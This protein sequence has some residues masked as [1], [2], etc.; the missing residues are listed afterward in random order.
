METF[1]CERQALVLTKPGCARLWLSAQENE[2]KPWEGRAKCL[3][4]PIGAAHA[5]RTIAPMAEITAELK[6]ICPRC[7][8]FA[9]RLIGKR[10]CVSCYN[11]Q[12]EVIVG[13]NAKGN[14]PLLASVLH[15]E[16]V[17]AVGPSGAKLL[18]ADLVASLP[19]LMIAQAAHAD[20]FAGFGRPPV[21]WGAPAIRQN[22]MPG[23]RS[24]IVP[25]PKRHKRR[26]RLLLPPSIVLPGASMTL[27]L[28]L[29]L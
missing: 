28:G 10:L 6:R 2:P 5:G 7:E 16:I 15:S 24:L 17:V 20:V 13:K 18:K 12:R 29:P 8:R 1:R 19:E 11:R 14:K 23:L 26:R 9:T 25:K 21:T 3:T 27:P 22:E 4:C